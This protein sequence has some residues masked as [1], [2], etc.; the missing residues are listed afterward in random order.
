[1]GVKLTNTSAGFRTHSDSTYRP[2]NI[3][4]VALLTDY[5]DGALLKPTIRQS[6][7]PDVKLVGGALSSLE[8]AAEGAA[9]F[10]LRRLQ[11]SAEVWRVERVREFLGSV[12]SEE[13]EE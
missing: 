13:Y 6:L 4:T 7:C 10:A 11:S 3:H 12:R 1:M 9:K 2:G 5:I 8:L